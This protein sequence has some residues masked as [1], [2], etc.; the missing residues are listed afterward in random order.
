V[1]PR[2][3]SRLKLDCNGIEEAAGIAGLGVQIPDVG[4]EKEKGEKTPDFLFLFF[5]SNTK[6]AH[7]T[8]SLFFL[9][10]IILTE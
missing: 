4:R 2:D 10:L 5:D 9:L 7:S 8:Q 1:P 6:T 3:F